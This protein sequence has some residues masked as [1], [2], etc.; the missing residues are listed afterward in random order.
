MSHDATSS[1]AAPTTHALP[2]FDEVYAAHGERLLNLLFRF[3]NNE[4]AARDLLQDVFVK[5]YQNLS[6]FRKEAEL[7]TWLHRIAVN[8]ALNYLKRERRT[9]W[10]N[11]LDE[12]VGTLLKQERIELPHWQPGDSPQPDHLLES[13]EQQEIVDR[14]VASLPL[15]YRAAYLLYRD[16]ELSTE[17]IAKALDI[18]TSAVESRIHRA[19]KLLIEKLKPLLSG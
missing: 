11:V 5:V 8:H 4:E 3:T 12:S 16:G 1:S 10:F 13:K 9:F 19:K 6:S 7:S 17:E 15:K 18:S 2:S 14:A